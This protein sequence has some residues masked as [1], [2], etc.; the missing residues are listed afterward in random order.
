MSFYGY[1]VPVSHPSNRSYACRD[2]WLKKTKPLLGHQTA[3]RTVYESCKA[4]VLTWKLVCPT[5]SICLST[6]FFS[7]FFE[8]NSI[9]ISIHSRMNGAHELLWHPQLKNYR[10][11][12]LSNS[13]LWIGW[14]GTSKHLQSPTH[15]CI[16]MSFCHFKCAAIGKKMWIGQLLQMACWGIYGSALSMSES[17]PKVPAFYSK[18]FSTQNNPSCFALF[19]LATFLNARWQK[20]LLLPNRPQNHLTGRPPAERER[21][22]AQNSTPS[23]LGRKRRRIQSVSMLSSM[24]A[25]PTAVMSRCR[26]LSRRPLFRFCCPELSFNL[27]SVNPLKRPSLRLLAL[28]YPL[29]SFVTSLSHL[30]QS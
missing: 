29:L 22:P 26:M 20:I 17:H 25:A 15:T 21:T 12:Q 6:L 10:K 13:I 28:I 5:L 23:R 9:F 11:R 16:Q 19:A 14:I 2:R 24:V 4:F 18:Y 30:V 7:R 27:R 3:T 8:D 1:L